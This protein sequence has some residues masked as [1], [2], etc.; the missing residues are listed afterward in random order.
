MLR[1]GGVDCLGTAAPLDSEQDQPDEN[2]LRSSYRRRVGSVSDPLRRGRA[3][4]RRPADWAQ[5]RPQGGAGGA[6]RERRERRTEDR[7]GVPAAPQARGA[8]AARARRRAPLGR[9]P[10]ATV[11][12]LRGGGRPPPDRPHRVRRARGRRADPGHHPGADRDPDVQ[13]RGV[14]DC[15]AGRPGGDG[16]GLRLP[17]HD[18][19]RGCGDRSE[20]GCGLDRAGRRRGRRQ[21]RRAGGRRDLE[22]T[23]RRTP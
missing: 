11:R 14:R 7:R 2:L 13:A 23:R 18:A 16:L 6:P 3:E 1:D 8:P 20:C 9:A 19:D 4:G 5:H 21:R 15:L 10:R 22:P 17:A 12:P